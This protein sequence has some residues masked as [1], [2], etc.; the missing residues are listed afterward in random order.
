MLVEAADL[1][2]LLELLVGAVELLWAPGSEAGR[3]VRLLFVLGRP[4]LMA[5]LGALVVAGGGDLWT[6]VLAGVKQVVTSLTGSVA[7]APH[8]LA[9]LLLVLG[10]PVLKP[11]LDSRN[12]YA[13]FT[14]QEVLDGGRGIA[15]LLESL[16][17]DVQ[18]V[19]AVASSDSLLEGWLELLVVV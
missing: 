8:G 6:P 7:G 19:L 17:E 18:L 4:V 14:G 5:Q 2:L 9:K 13:G 15:V 12:I 10:A 11:D 16:L 3:L 1:L